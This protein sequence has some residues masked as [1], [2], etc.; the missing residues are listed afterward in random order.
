[1]PARIMAKSRRGVWSM[2]AADGHEPPQ[3]PHWMHISRRAT[4]AVAA[5][6][7]SSNLRLGLFGSGGYTV[8][9]V[10]GH[11]LRPGGKCAN[12]LHPQGQRPSRFQA[13]SRIQ[14]PSY[15]FSPNN[16]TKP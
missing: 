6:T 14:P 16:T 8:G 1:M 2:S 13:T 4:P 3:V 10:K 15:A 9:V 5:L 7:S 11:L 12:G